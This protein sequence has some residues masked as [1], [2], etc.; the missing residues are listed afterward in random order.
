[1]QDSYWIL[2]FFWHCIHM[3]KRL[4]ELFLETKGVKVEKRLYAIQ[5]C[6]LFNLTLAY[7]SSYFPVV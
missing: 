7:I 5:Y 4:C 3:D 1:M 2:T 6:L